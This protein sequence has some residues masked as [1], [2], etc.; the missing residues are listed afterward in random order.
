MNELITLR[1]TSQLEDFIKNYKSVIFFES[2]ETNNICYLDITSEMDPEQI[3]KYTN[4]KLMRQIYNY[5]TD[6]DLDYQDIIQILN[7]KNKTKIYDMTYTLKVH[8]KLIFN[9]IL[10]EILYED[11]KFTQ[12]QSIHTN[13]LSLEFINYFTRNKYKYIEQNN[14]V[15]IS[16]I[17]NDRASYFHIN[18]YFSNSIRSIFVAEYGSSYLAERKVFKEHTDIKIYEN[19]I[20]NIDYGF[21]SSLYDIFVRHLEISVPKIVKTLFSETDFFIILS[22]IHFG[23]YVN[24]C[25]YFIFHYNNDNITQLFETKH[26]HKIY[27]LPV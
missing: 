18:F 24:S 22:Q 4:Q 5:L 16:M 26:I 6:N 20:K 10:S 17:S 13:P 9:V 19:I 2:K 25:G 23:R 14:Y 21:N 27:I 1:V 15:E 3:H 11:G 7:L 8:D 12:K